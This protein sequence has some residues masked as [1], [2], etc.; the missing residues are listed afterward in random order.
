MLNPIQTLCRIGITSLLFILACNTAVVA[1]TQQ[2]PESASNELAAFADLLKSPAN[3]VVTISTNKGDIVIE[4]FEKEAPQSVRNFL[5][6]VNSGYYTGTIF[7]RV[8]PDFMIQG[9]GF[10]ESLQKKSGLAETIE[11]E[12]DNGLKNERGTLAM[13]RTQDPHSATSQFFINAKDNDFLDFKA[14]NRSGWGYAVFGRVIQGM[15]I[16]EAIEAST[17]TTKSGH[18]DVPEQTVIMESVSQ[19][20]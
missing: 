7:H 16:V 13:A 1:A 6:Y 18:R 4:L 15:D 8:I 19:L 3:P 11:N 14:K 12:A 10:S 5:Y 9:G 2:Q 20:R 17:T